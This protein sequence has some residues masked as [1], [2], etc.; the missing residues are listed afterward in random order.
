MF[1][2]L[3]YFFV[4]E[5]LPLN[6]R[7][8]FNVKRKKFSLDDARGITKQMLEGLQYCHGLNKVHGDLKSSNILFDYRFNQQ[9]YYSQTKFICF[10][11][12]WIRWYHLLQASLDINACIHH[13][14]P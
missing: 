10:D 4:Y 3:D 6:V 8:F 13:V 14:E 11:Q 5:Y 12:F 2:Y 9:L 1:L 7:E